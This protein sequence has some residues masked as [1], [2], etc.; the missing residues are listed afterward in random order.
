MPELPEV[1][2]IVRDLREKIVG[3]KIDKAEVVEGSVI[4]NSDEEWFKSAL[5]GEKIADIKRRG[6]Y[7]LFLLHSGKILV[8]HL[9]MTGQLVYSEP[10]SPVQKHLCLNLLLSAAEKRLELRY[11]DIRKFG[12]IYLL[13]PE[14][15]LPGL[16]KLGPEPFAADFSSAYLTQ[17]LAK[18]KQKIKALLLDQTVIAGI[19]NIYADEILFRAGVRPDRLSSSLSSEEIERLVYWTPLVLGEAIKHR[20]TTISDYRDGLGKKGEFQNFLRVYGRAG[21][22]CPVCRTILLKDKIAGRT[23]TFCPQCQK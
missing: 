4:K 21:E 15:R 14:E 13:L 7:L 3:Y 1:E 9:R 5:T 17:K 22:E 16:E 11:Y 12:F 10:S 23:S 6:K 2:T 18:R 19:G 20:G 8:V